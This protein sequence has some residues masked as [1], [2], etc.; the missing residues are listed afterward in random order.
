V[1]D[2]DKKIVN[3]YSTLASIIIDENKRDILTPILNPHSI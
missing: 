2:L 3:G 1:L